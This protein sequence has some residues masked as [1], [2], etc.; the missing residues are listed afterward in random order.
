MRWVLLAREGDR[1]R[2]A[3]QKKI[4]SII[5]LLLFPTE[6][7]F[8]REANFFLLSPS[9][10]WEKTFCL[11]AAALVGREESEQTKPVPIPFSGGTLRLFS[12]P[13]Y[14]RLSSSSLYASAFNS[15]MI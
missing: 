5:P 12:F 2:T 13:R 4:I 11:A 9:F 1:D 3:L 8:V 14:Y 10:L 6:G 7:G 15:E